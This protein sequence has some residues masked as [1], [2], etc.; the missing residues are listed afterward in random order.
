M[1]I[2]KLTTLLLAIAAAPLMLAA[3]NDEKPEVTAGETQ[4]PIEAQTSEE[5]KPD[6]ILLLADNGKSD[7]TLIRSEGASGY[8]LDTAKAVNQRLK[9]L[10][11]D[12]KFSD[13]WVHPTSTAH[14]EAHELLLFTTNRAESEATMAELSFE[15]YIIRITDC[16]IVIVGSSPASCNE[17]L[18]HFFDRIV[19]E[20]TKDGRIELPVGLEIKQ[21]VAAEAI[22]IDIQA[23]LSSGKTVCAD[24]E[25]VFNYPRKDGFT[26]AQGSATDGKY[27]YVIMKDASGER[28]VD[29]VVKVDMA[30][31][32]VV[33]ESE[34]MPLDHA[35]DMTYDPVNDVLIVTNMYDNLISFID[36]KDLT[37]I[38]QKKAVFGSWATG[39]YEGTEQYVFLAYG[40]PSGLLITDT[41]L[42]PI[43][44]SALT[45]AQGY[46]G[47][48]MGTD[49]KLAYVPLS[50]S[51]GKSDNIIQIYELA[52]G[53]YLGLISVA[54]KMESESMF[55]VGDDYYIHFNN[56]GSKI[57][58][59]NFYIR[60]E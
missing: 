13:D 47:Q 8:Y 44:S 35:N 57:A 45:S 21:E 26:S 52:T 12:I 30:T 15:G 60:F 23:A 29:R 18:Y 42:A 40:S 24:F 7:F 53:K 59:L 58:K 19:P 54:T 38:E 16:K 22:A 33:L 41:N 10:S 11:E 6:A 36:P 2:K 32:S 20:Y 25:V 9:K 43:R 27:A 31:W 4:D 56:S 37:L 3:C 14:L 1:N 50:P 51:T 55:H 28:E 46:V 48:G 5:A 39:Y 49:S 17:A 34:T